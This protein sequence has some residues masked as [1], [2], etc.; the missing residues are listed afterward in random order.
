[1]VIEGDV[2]LLRRYAARNLEMR[3]VVYVRGETPLLER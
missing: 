1:M 3:R 2:L